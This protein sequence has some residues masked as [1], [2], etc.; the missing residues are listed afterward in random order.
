MFFLG[1]WDLLVLV[2]IRSTL[3]PFTDLGSVVCIYRV[4][5]I[6]F[7]FNE[8]WERMRDLFL[9][10]PQWLVYATV[11]SV[12]RLG[13]ERILLMPPV[14]YFAWKKFKLLRSLLQAP[15]VVVE[16]LPGWIRSFWFGFADD[17]NS[18][19]SSPD[20]GMVVF[21]RRIIWDR[22]TCDRVTTVS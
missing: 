13:A 14:P 20:V 6:H 4:G 17:D 1:L 15:S 11:Q 22:Y 21:L 2:I 5:Y 7:L 9:T 12:S 3:L 10:I 16:K 8:I 18:F 19:Y